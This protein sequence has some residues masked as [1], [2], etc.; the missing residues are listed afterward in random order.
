MIELSLDKNVMFY[1]ASEANGVEPA[2]FTPNSHLRY[3]TAGSSVRNF[4]QYWV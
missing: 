2:L 1:C 3:V 4:V